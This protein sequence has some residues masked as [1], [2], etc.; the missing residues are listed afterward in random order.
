MHA[1]NYIVHLSLMVLVK[2]FE[3]YIIYNSTLKNPALHVQRISIYVLRGVLQ[4]EPLVLYA[5]FSDPSLIE[6]HCVLCE[7]RKEFYIHVVL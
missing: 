2:C 1:T 7:K 4:Q 6:A 5:T 3:D